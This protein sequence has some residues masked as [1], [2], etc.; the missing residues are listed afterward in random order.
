MRATAA[1]RFDSIAWRRHVPM[2]SRT[3]A[4]GP[5]KASAARRVALPRLHSAPSDLQ[6]SATDRWLQQRTAR[7]A[8]THCDA[9]KSQRVKARSRWWRSVAVEWTD[10]RRS[11]AASYV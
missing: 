6:A 1:R 2:K 7:L 5:P 10:S 11:A 3:A 4:N 9:K 8:A